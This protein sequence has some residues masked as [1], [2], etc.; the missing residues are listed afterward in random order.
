[1]RYAPNDLRNVPKS[2]SI[3]NNFEECRP[4]PLMRIEVRFFRYIAQAHFVR[5]QIRADR[6][7]VVEDIAVRRFDEA[8]NHLERSGFARTVRT[9]VSSDLSCSCREADIVHYRDARVPLGD[10]PKFEHGSDP[11]AQDRE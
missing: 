11:P 1:L 6:R 5:D 10:V 2:I 4:E 9:Q 8:S 7:A 3:F